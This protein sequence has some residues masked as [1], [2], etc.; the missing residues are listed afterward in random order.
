MARK[1]S[2][3]LTQLVP[4]KK[5]LVCVVHLPPLPGSPRWSKDMQIDTIIDFAI[6]CARE[7]EDGGADAVI[8]ENFGD[9]PFS[10]RVTDPVTLSS[11]S[12][13]VREVAK[14]VNIP[15][16]V[17]L[18]RNSCP[19]ALAIAYAAGAAF[20]RCNM[21][22]EVVVCPEGLIEPVAHEVIKLRT[23]L[24]TDIEIL[25]DILVKHAY[26][27]H[28]MTLRDLIAD[29]TERCMADILVI[30]GS[31]TGEPPDIETVND[32]LRHSKVPV[33]IGSGVTPDNV[34]Q[35]RNAHGF[36]VGTFVKRSDG[37]I[38]RTRVQKLRRA[39][40]NL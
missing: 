1:L 9:N 27:L 2:V 28:K 8:L 3:R 20:I 29:C 21:Y 12:I 32:V 13:I 18:L 15:V 36:I 24:G 6:R 7:A 40:D 22:C 10:K 11:M 38:D 25:A 5:V 35:F 14:S 37:T 30:T 33:F 23:Y 4:K 16:G 19:E 17:N 39:I 34:R 31:R 26:P